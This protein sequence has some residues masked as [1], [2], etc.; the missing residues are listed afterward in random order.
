LL[1]RAHRWRGPFDAHL[2]EILLERAERILAADGGRHCNRA[3]TE[4]EVDLLLAGD[5]PGAA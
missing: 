3:L 1:H 2:A 5:E 4:A